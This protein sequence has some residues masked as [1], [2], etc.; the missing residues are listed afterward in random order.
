MNEI[1]ISTAFA[2]LAT[3][4]ALVITEANAGF[5]WTIDDNA[6]HSV[7]LD[8]TGT[9]GQIT[10]NGTVGG[11]TVSG[12]AYSKPNIGSS[13]LGVM[14]FSPLKIT[15]TGAVAAPLTIKLSDTDFPSTS[16]GRDEATWVGSIANGSATGNAYFDPANTDFATGG[17]HIALGTVTAADSSAVPI[18][19][20]S[21]LQAFDYG[22][23]TFSE[24][25]QLDVTATGA[26]NVNLTSVRAPQIP[27]PEPSSF[28]IA[29][30][31]GVFLALF[32]IFRKPVFIIS[33]TN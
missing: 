8:D 3:V 13:T 19:F 5:V 10:F 25:I 23:V 2:F 33:A 7:N 1:R 32:R 24:F 18:N 9:P 11:Y 29:G 20:D 17:L 14:S 4:F 28:V 21:G 6:G 30:I 22:I 31:G 27:I 16:A 15:T 12:T 26:L